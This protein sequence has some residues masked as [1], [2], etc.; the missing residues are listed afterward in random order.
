[1][2]VLALEEVYEYYRAQ[3]ETDKAQTLLE[4]AL[5]QYPYNP[6][7]HARK[8]A[9]ALETGDYD[10][11]LALARTAHQMRPYDVNF[12][13]LESR[14]LAAQEQYD[15]AH[16]VLE[17]ALDTAQDPLEIYFYRARVYQLQQKPSHAVA[18]YR[19]AL[20]LNPEWEEALIEL[21]Y[22]YEDVLNEPEAA[23]DYLTG[24]LDEHPYHAAAWFH[25]GNLRHKLGLYE[26]AIDAYDYALV[27]QD[28][29]FS[30][31][32][33]KAT[34]FMELERYTEAIRTLLETL[35]TDRNDLA[36]LLALGECYEQL[37][38]FSRARYYYSKCIEINNEL[39]DAYYGMGS[40][41]EAEERYL[42]AIHYYKRGLEHNKEFLDAWL[43]LADCEYQLGNPA[44]AYE[45]LQQAIRLAPDDRELWRTWAERL[46]EDGNRTA[47]LAFLEEGIKHNPTAADLLYQ[48]A[49][50]ALE[51]RRVPEALNYL[52]NA[53]IMN[54]A[55]SYVL[56]TYCPGAV[57]I[58]QVA[59]LLG[60]YNARA[61]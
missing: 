44:S 54:P 60:Q 42:E 17:E 39:P 43:G 19:K 14:A 11:A 34:A 27:I 1:M 49:A 29:F 41:L 20:E 51:A 47:A 37:E 23:I 55:E 13:L 59:H 5:K 32:Y 6:D 36:C 48:Y 3:D 35:L 7:F 38:D 2:D 61:A 30:A 24:F 18:C 22:C 28:D 57:E 16:Q 21:V 10:D 25:L 45:A 46:A 9:L 4:F 31:Y 52:E 33:G 12:R 53:L 26:L 40:T 50:Y 58:P 56:G 8:A 15:E